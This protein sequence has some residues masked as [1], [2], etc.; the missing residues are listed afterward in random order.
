MIIFSYSVSFSVSF[1]LIL[2]GH[3]T[4]KIKCEE[5]I[6]RRVQFPHEVHCMILPLFVFAKC[7]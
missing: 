4:G 6:G 7:D 5:E 2:N 3:C 1:Y